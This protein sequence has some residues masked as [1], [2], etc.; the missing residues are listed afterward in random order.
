LDHILNDPAPGGALVFE[1]WRGADG[2]RYRV[3][4][5]YTAQS[6]EQ[7]RM[8]TALKLTDPPGKAE[9]FLPGC[10]TASAGFACDWEDFER[11]VSAAI[12]PAF[13]ER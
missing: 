9:I 11:T 4:V 1:L 8:Q 12:D 5:Y 6:M 10:S 2:K 13:V 3:R 7:M